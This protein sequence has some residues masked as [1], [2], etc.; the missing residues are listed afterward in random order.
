MNEATEV[1]SGIIN[2]HKMPSRKRGGNP[3]EGGIPPRL[4]KGGYLPE[5]ALCVSE[6]YP[7]KADKGGEEGCSFSPRESASQE[8][9]GRHIT[10]LRCGQQRQDFTKGW[11]M[12]AGGKEEKDK[13]EKKKK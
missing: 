6:R 3:E 12:A 7:E 1:L 13:K 9:E 11:G 4:E 2:T 8:R 5:A 10:H